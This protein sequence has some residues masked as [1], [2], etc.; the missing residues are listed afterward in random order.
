MRIRSPHSLSHDYIFPVALDRVIGELARALMLKGF[1]ALKPPDAI[2]IATAAFVNAEAMHTFD[3]KLIQLN[4]LIDQRDGTK[5]KICKPDAGA[6]P[7][8]LLDKMYENEDEAY[9]EATRNRAKDS[10]QCRPRQPS[11]VQTVH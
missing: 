10:R 9:N 7:A 1:S 8:P 11:A 6:T 3:G 2:H 4:R 5:L